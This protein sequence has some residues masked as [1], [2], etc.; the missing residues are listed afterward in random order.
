MACVSSVS[1]LVLMN[2]NEHGFIKPE[3]GIRQ[4]NPLSPFLFILCAEA[5]VSCLKVAESSGRLHGIKL[6]ASGPSFHHLLFAD[7]GLLMCRATSEEASEL[8]SC[9]RK[10]IE[11]SGQIINP[12]KSSIIFGSKVN[13]ETKDEVK[14]VL[15][16]HTLGGE[17]FYLGLPECFNGSKRKLLSFIREKLQGRLKG[18]F[19]KSLSQGGKEILLK[20]ACLALPVY[21]MSCFKLPKDVCAK[22]TSVMVECWWSSGNNRR[23]I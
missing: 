17:D 4:G 21:A 1:F 6:A 3:R 19:A 15:G 2:E 18:W 10:Y 12:L 16:I 14:L 7:D 20:S 5:L 23:K 8:I 13:E 22:L 9:L 11:A